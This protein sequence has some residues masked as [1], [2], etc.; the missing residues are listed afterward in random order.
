M[1]AF[2]DWLYL[3]ALQTHQEF[4]KRLFAYKGFTDIEFNPERSINCQARSCALLVA[5]LRLDS[6]NEALRSQQDF[7]EATSSGV[8]KETYSAGPDYR[9]MPL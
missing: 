9:Q 6:L 4:L 8:F 5:L 1:T 2:Y 3:S 7:I